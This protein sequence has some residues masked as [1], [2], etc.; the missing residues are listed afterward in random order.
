MNSIPNRQVICDTLI[1]L[2]GKDKDIV[3]LTSDSRGSASMTNFA[4]E[5]PE[6]FVEVGIAEQNIVGIA[7]GLA[8]SGKKPY[9]ASPAC[10]LSMRSIEQVKV[11]VAY[12]K[13]NVKLI[14]IS[15]GLSYGAL[16]MSHHSLQDIAVMRAIP[17]INIILPAD[18]HETKKMIEALAKNTEPTYIR[19]G[20]NPVAD[21]Y[22]SDEY[23][24][25]IGKAVTMSEG[26]D[27][28]IIAAGETVK[29]A[30]DAADMLKKK[31]V[32][33][34]VLNM[35]TIKPLDE[36]EII[37]A[38]KETGCIITVEEHSIY[39]GLGAAVSEVVTQNCP[40]PMKIVGVPDEP[41]IP[42]KSEEVF[43]HYGLT[44]D[45]I[46]SIAL[47]IIKKK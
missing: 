37:K 46:S 5:L 41:A 22:S 47:E 15:G 10:F 27:I 12:S 9:I 14:G 40:V 44:A 13:T 25:E 7:A 4:K 35:H 20:R 3:V 6:Q 45:N 8:A 29:I 33:C 28:T 26:T 24:F 39:G 1:E 42:G 38:A 2:G 19:I 34:R 17:G 11:D 21:V 43:K 31:G 16:G 23:S 18:K 32:S 36:A 30:M